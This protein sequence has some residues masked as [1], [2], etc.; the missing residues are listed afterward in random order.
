MRRVVTRFVHFFIFDDGRPAAHVSWAAVKR[1]EAAYGPEL[2]EAS[3]FFSDYELV[4][5]TGSEAHLPELQRT[6]S[7]R[8]KRKRPWGAG[9]F[10]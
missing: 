6:I 10:T 5:A 3:V 1:F 2:V 9:V 4:A 7:H 8:T